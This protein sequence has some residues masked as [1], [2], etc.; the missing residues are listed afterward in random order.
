QTPNKIDDKTTTAE[1]SVKQSLAK[2]RTIFNPFNRS[3][4]EEQPNEAAK[5]TA[6]PATSTSTGSKEAIEKSPVKKASK[7]FGNFFSRSKS[8]H[9]VNEGIAATG[10]TNDNCV[11]TELPQIEQLQPIV[12]ELD[13]KESEATVDNDKKEADVKDSVT[14]T[15]ETDVA[16]INSTEAEQATQAPVATKRQ[17]FISKLFGKK[18]QEPITTCEVEETANTTE[19][20][21]VAADSLEANEEEVGTPATRSSSPLGRLT[22]LFSSKKGNKKTK[23]TSNVN[24]EEQPAA[25]VEKGEEQNASTDTKEETAN[26]ADII[27]NSTPAVVLASA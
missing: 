17:S 3:K 2:R 27:T 12:T 22:E 21:A 13:A 26:V 16:Q 6:E 24:E 18:K 5:E 4:K 25:I 1:V 9:K 11:S 19:E 7:G 23:A 10:E 15:V 8:S 20:S 14:E